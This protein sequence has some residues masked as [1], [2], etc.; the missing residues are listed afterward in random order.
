MHMCMHALTCTYTCTS[1]YTCKYA[2]S[3]T[4]TRTLH[5]H[6]HRA[7]QA[8]THAQQAAHVQGRM[9]M[10]LH[11]KPH[12]HKRTPNTHHTRTCTRTNAS[13]AQTFSRTCAMTHLRTNSRICSCPPPHLIL[14]C[15]ETSCDILC[16][17]A[18]LL[19]CSLCPDVLAPAVHAEP[20]NPR[21]MFCSP[22]RLPIDSSISSSSSP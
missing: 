7:E 14:D 4:H 21:V 3:Y 10:T 2:C 6:A 11:K 15:S 22:V 13:H 5:M 17:S 1:K 8:E 12:I 19:P 18:A 9:H 16:I 20:G